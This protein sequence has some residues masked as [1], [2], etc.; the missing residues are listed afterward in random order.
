MGR[1]GDKRE[2]GRNKT[3]DLPKLRGGMS[4]NPNSESEGKGCI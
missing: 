1:C 2:S 3:A 4:K